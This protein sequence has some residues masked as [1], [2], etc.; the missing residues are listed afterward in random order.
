MNACANHPYL[1]QRAELSGGYFMKYCGDSCP[2]E[3]HS[4]NTFCERL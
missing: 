4:E 2:G 3:K 1:Q